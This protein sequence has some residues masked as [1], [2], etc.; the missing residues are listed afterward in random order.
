MIAL[1]LAEIATAVDG[2]LE[3]AD[4]AVVV[5]GPVVIDSRE[6]VPGSLFVAITGE[7]VD[8]HTYARAAIDAGA[9]A[10]LAERPVPGVPT[11]V[12]RHGVAESRNV[13]QPTVVALGALAGAVRRRLEGT[14]VIALTGSSGKTSTKDLLAHVLG[15][16]GPTVA[17]R[18]SQNN[19]IGFPLTVLA[20]REDTRFLVLEMGA[21]QVGHIAAL[22]AIARPDVSVVLNV[23]LAHVGIF[24]DPDAV[25]A[26]KSEI[27]QALPND[28]VAIL[29]ADDPRTRAMA[30]VTAARVVLF[31]EAPDAAV[32]ARHVEL[33]EL[34][35]A[36]FDLVAEAGVAHVSL[37]V[38]G[39]HQV[40]NALAA[41]AVALAVGAE[42][43]VVAA[44]LST[45][46]G[47]SPMRMDVTTTPDGVVL[48]DDTYNANPSSM[49][50]ALKALI[51]MGHGHRTFAVLGE[52]RE[53]GELSVREHDAIG[54]LAVRLNVSQ[55]VAVGQGAKVLHLGA[56]NE[57]SWDQE[58]KWFADADAALEFLRAT[59]RHGDVVLVK[60]SRS[61]G[62]EVISDA[63]KQPGFTLQAAASRDTESLASDDPKTGE[64]GAPA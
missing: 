55:V 45:A 13:D 60:A 22:C 34:A 63:L 38:F 37:G 24:G 18:G 43:D 32:A 4:G 31:G 9:V 57:G 59:V 16:L 51:A 52:M 10:V 20:A 41:A 62:L 48:I 11:I 49:R 26:A 30:T 58:S 6:V 17:A 54:R 44:R 5:T 25:A 42:L 36:R 50:A 46:T 15:G 7:R 56:A 12:V 53:L 19:E 14:T 23:G 3:G 64:R 35:R 33:D 27:V 21:R 29:N 1:T 39:E 61:I 40:S 8:G 2:H 28:G 47:K